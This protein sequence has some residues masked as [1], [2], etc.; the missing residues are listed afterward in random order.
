MKKS[1]S[2]VI[3][4]FN[5][6]GNIP[7]LWSRLGQ[8]LPSTGLPCEVIF[9]DDGSIDASAEL[10]QEICRNDPRARLIQLSRNF[11][12]QSA[13]AAGIDHARG[14]AV[15]LM[16]GDLQDR[17]ESIPDFV[18]EW[19]GG[20]EVVYAVRVTRR[21]HFPLN[22]LFKSFY[23]I[24]AL[25]SGIKM[26]LDSGIFG[27]LDRRAVDVIRSMPERNRYFPGLRAY[28]GFR[29][30]G[31]AVDRDPRFAG[32]SRVGLLGLVRLA[33]D[34]MIS[35]SYAPL[36]IA[37]YSGFVISGLAFAYILRVLYKKWVSGEAIPGW[38]STLTAILFLGGVQLIVSGIIGEYIGRIYD[39][40]KKRP[41]YI[42][43]H[44]VNFTAE[45]KNEPK[46]QG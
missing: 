45:A 11:G 40:V 4:I 3:P 8:A 26:P 35:F 25:I 42:I 43:S 24:L 38:A 19:Q 16:D 34:G 33:V 10:L 36:R 15:V 5:E 31:V 17:P 14:D 41:F 44:R 22:L 39:E 30:K 21:E 28:A 1:I 13:L 2:V 9:V 27:L 20:V 37:T 18:K 12:H 23:R 29:Q 32:T 7:E 6:A 46:E